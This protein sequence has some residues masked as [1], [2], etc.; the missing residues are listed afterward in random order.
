MV[1]LAIAELCRFGE[2]N[3]CHAFTGLICT[4]LAHTVPTSLCSRGSANEK[5]PIRL[6]YSLLSW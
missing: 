3:R 4:F 1:A 2:A 6:E 5:V